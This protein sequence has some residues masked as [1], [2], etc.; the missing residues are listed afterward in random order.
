MASVRTTRRRLGACVATVLAVTVGAGVLG[1]PGAAAASAPAA[2]S[3]AGTAATTATAAANLPLDA[4]IVSTGDTGYLTSRKDDSG[5]TVLEWRAYADGSVLPITTGT[6]GHESHSDTVVTSD[7]GSTVFLRDMR[8]GGTLSASFD[9]AAEFKPGAKL[10]GVV[11]ENLFVKVPTGTADYHELW[12][13]TP[14]DGVARKTLR[15]GGGY[16][17]DFKVVAATSDAMLLLSSNRVFPSPAT[18]KTEFWLTRRNVDPD[19]A[20]KEGSSANTAP[21]THASTGAFSADYE[22]WV[23]YRSGAATLRVEGVYV[24]RT[25]TLDSS[26]SGAVIAGVLQDTLLYGVPGKAADETPSPLYARNVKSST[27]APYKLMEHFSSVAHAPDGGL[28]VRGATAEADGLFR[29]W[30][31]DDGRPTATLVAAT[32]RVPAVKVTESKVP[33]AVDLEKPGTTVPMEWTLSRANATVDLTL[34][35][36]ATGTKLTRRLARP[37]TGSRFAFTWDGVLDGISAPNG[38]YTWQLTAT[39]ADGAGAPATASGSLQVSRRANPHDA[40]DNGSTDV[41]ARDASGVLWRDDLFDWPSGDRD[42]TAKRTRIG[43][44]WQIYN[45]IEATGNIAGAPA[46][47]LVARDASGVLWLYLGKGDG[48]FAPRAKVGGGWQIYDKITAGSDLTGDGRPDLL[49]TDTSGVLWLY[50]GTGSWSAPFAPR[51]RVGGGWQIYNEITAVGDIVGGTAGDL[52]ARDTSG[53]LW[54]YQGNGAGDFTTRVRI[55]AGWNAFSHLVGAGD[56][57]ADG[58]PDLVAYGPGG[59]YVYGSTG[60]PTAPFSRRTTTLYAGEGTAFNHI[61]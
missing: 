3:V 16:G 20:V 48:T 37:A 24:H 40:N 38:A 35:H 23:E 27:A 29:I 5:A 4:E 41:L 30:P 58:R 26:M 39:P 31:G 1:S 19:S 55:G 14:V 51:T 54:L 17:L 13:L 42:T 43:A 59:T 22:S 10:V 57:T 61:A 7:G 25:Y 8:E 21:W 34:T 52:V 2:V 50:K 47:D 18:R 11:G 45:R 12:Q 33:T 15:L 28:L 49:A 60:S 9:L 46:G 36:P 53:V 6:V 56:V 32:G 44:G